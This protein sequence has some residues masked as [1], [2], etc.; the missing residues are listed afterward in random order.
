MGV[1]GLGSADI[2]I[3]SG[4]AP[5]ATARVFNDAGPSGTTGFTEEAMRAEEAIPSG[6]NGVLLIPPD[7]TVARFNAGVRT[8][9]EGA[10]VTLSLKNA[11]G[12]L[13]G[14]RTQALPPN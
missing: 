10:S 12:M 8:L 2:E 5:V 4:A 1:S 3:T 13:V 9:G 6:Q 11:A 14:S 7:L